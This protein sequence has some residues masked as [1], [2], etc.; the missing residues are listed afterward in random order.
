MSFFQ[1]LFGKPVT[2]NT[3][4]KSKPT[5]NINSLREQ[6]E[7][8]ILETGSLSWN[9][10]NLSELNVCGKRVYAVIDGNSIASFNTH[11]KIIS[12]CYTH[13]QPIDSFAIDRD[14]KYF[15]FTGKDSKIIHLRSTENTGFI[16]QIEAEN[17]VTALVMSKRNLYAG[18][19][20]CGIEKHSWDPDQPQKS[21]IKKFSFNLSKLFEGTTAV[22]FITLSPKNDRI[23]FI[24]GGILAV[25]KT[26]VETEYS[27]HLNDINRM[28]V[29][30]SNNGKHIAAA[31]GSYS[32]SFDIQSGLMSITNAKGSL[33]IFNLDNDN[34]F[35]YSGE[36]CW[37]EDVVWLTS[38]NKILCL[39]KVVSP[40]GNS[41]TKAISI[42]D[43]DLFIAGHQQPEY[44]AKIPESVRLNFVKATDDGGFLMEFEKNTDND[45]TLWCV[46]EFYLH[47]DPVSLKRGKSEQQT[48][49]HTVNE[50][51]TPGLKESDELPEDHGN[52]VSEAIVQ[53]TGDTPDSEIL[54][55]ISQLGRRDLL[56][57]STHWHRLL[58]LGNLAIPYLIPLLDN[59][60]INVV[61][62]AAIMLGQIGAKGAIPKLKELSRSQYFEIHKA[63]LTALANLEKKGNSSL[64]LDKTNAYSQISSMWTA[65]IQGR[66]DLYPSEILHSFCME[67]IS[68]MPELNFSSKSEEARA[69]GM[70]GS[71]TFKSL[72]A[73]WPGGFDMTSQCSEARKCY[74]EA[75]R[76]EPGDSW[77]SDWVTR[78]S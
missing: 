56:G 15:T 9:R 57:P 52:I 10:G 71:L 77:W 28:S 73:E 16:H 32:A 37:I 5:W 33:K 47:T 26:G 18:T 78:F 3:S 46:A 61:S 1:K 38:S 55:L 25:S 24:V 74:E 41:V 44:I 22:R 8:S 62:D 72:H 45:K 19:E 50:E 58:E 65:I 12:K 11:G 53:E 30:F 36:H 2:P 29:R 66:E 64:K 17:N 39:L 67:T 43:V 31:G 59:S 35:E 4:S 21:P 6:I 75:L 60:D 27:L 70:L 14:G 68:E 40:K 49:Y 69:W 42:H 13:D 63:A 51:I 7:S 48:E 23:A 34:H 54:S 20:S 76:C